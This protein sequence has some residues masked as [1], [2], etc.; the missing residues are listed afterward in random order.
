M[1]KPGDLVRFIQPAPNVKMEGKVFFVNAIGYTKH[2]ATSQPLALVEELETGIH[3]DFQCK[4][5]E[6]VNDSTKCPN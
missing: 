4:Y 6:V 5:L 1:I 3:Y 2:L